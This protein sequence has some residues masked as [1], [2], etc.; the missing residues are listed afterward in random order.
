MGRRLPGLCAVP[1]AGRAWLVA[2]FPAPFGARG[3]GVYGLS[4]WAQRCC[5]AFTLS[6]NVQF[7]EPSQLSDQ[8]IRPLRDV[9]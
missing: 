9:P 6:P 5:S 1:A 4:G 2:R 8:V 7:F 3:T